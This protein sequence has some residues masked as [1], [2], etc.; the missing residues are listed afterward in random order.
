MFYVRIHPNLKSLKKYPDQR[1][2]RIKC[3]KFEYYSGRFKDRFLSTDGCMRKN[4]NL[5]LN[6]GMKVFLGQPSILIAEQCM[7]T[8]KDAIY[9]TN[10]RN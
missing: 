4:K 6:M 3:P 5:W 2:E 1:I 9:P 10:R 8:L 7:K